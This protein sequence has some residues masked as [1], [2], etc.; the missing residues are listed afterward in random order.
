MKRNLSLVTKTQ[1][2][3]NQNNENFDSIPCTARGFGLPMIIR[4]EEGEDQ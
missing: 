2:D 1:S 4:K 3:I